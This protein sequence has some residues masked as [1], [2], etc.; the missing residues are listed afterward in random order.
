MI[1]KWL[2]K[3]DI[4]WPKIVVMSESFVTPWTVDHQA[5][6]S[7]GFPR[8]KILDG[9]SFPSSGDWI[10]LNQGSNLYLSYLGRWVLYHW[11]TSKAPWLWYTLEKYKRKYYK[12]TFAGTERGKGFAPLVLTKSRQNVKVQR[13]C[14]L[15]FGF[16][17]SLFENQLF[18]LLRYFSM[19]VKL[20]F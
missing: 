4:P 6:L 19:L 13:V 20:I 10:F 5:P 3:D 16:N 9:L 2:L 1:C 8:Q 15:P 14:L 18:F 17:Y 12:L 7:M 11:A